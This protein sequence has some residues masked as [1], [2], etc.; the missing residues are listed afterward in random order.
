MFQFVTGVK[1]PLSRGEG[2][3]LEGKSARDQIGLYG[4]ALLYQTGRGLFDFF[5]GV[6]KMVLGVQ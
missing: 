4:L 6:N 5:V 3:R 2:W 1:K